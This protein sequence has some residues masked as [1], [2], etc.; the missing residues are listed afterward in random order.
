MTVMPVVK[1]AFSIMNEAVTNSF[2]QTEITVKDANR[3]PTKQL[4]EILGNILAENDEYCKY[5]LEFNLL[6]FLYSVYY[7][8]NNNDV[9]LKLEVLFCWMNIA[10]GQ[11]SQ[12]L[13]NASNIQD[14]VNNVERINPNSSDIDYEVA[15]RS[16]VILCNFICECDDNVLIV[17]MILLNRLVF[18]SYQMELRDYFKIT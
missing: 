13:F 16:I 12:V 14:L 1:L 18:S 9:L 11:Y 5:L 2:N 8:Q 7:D 15:R 4:L 6:P 10:G 3:Y 17:Q